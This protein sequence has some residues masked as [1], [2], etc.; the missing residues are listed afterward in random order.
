MTHDDLPFGLQMIRTQESKRRRAR[1]DHL[2][3]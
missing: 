3:G 1:A 2:D